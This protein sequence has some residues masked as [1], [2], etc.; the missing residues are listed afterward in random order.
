M[1]VSGYLKYAAGDVWYVITYMNL[2]QGRALCNKYGHFRSLIHNEKNHK[3]A[4]ET[5]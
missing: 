2:G 1:G 3:Y 5:M 4:I